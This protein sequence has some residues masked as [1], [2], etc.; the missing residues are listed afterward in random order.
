MSKIPSSESV[1]PNEYKTSCFIKNVE[2]IKG[3]L[4]YLD[5]INCEKYRKEVVYYDAK[6]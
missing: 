3:I 1:F 6:I 2:A 5:I 4:K